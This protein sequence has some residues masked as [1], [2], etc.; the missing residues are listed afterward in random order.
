MTPAT[1]F[2]TKQV[3]RGEKAVLDA[4]DAAPG[5]LKLADLASQSG[6]SVRAVSEH[7]RTL[8]GKGK[9]ERYRGHGH[10]LFYRRRRV[11]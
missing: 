9:V 3:A 10:D 6:L 5:G 2:T 8:R 11:K 7:V 1:Y 4:L